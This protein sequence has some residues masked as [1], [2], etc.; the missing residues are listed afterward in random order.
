MADVTLRAEIVGG[1]KAFVDA[2]KQAQAAMGQ[3]ANE[4]DK[5]VASAKISLDGL[6]DMLGEVAKAF[7]VFGAAATGALAISATNAATF[8]NEMS[9]VLALLSSEDARSL[10]PQLAEGARQIRTE[11]GLAGQEVAEA[12][13]LAIGSGVPAAEAVDFLGKSA[14]AAVSGMVALKDVV[15]VTA[16][17]V[18]AM[19][20]EVSETQR[21]QDALAMA[22]NLGTVEWKDF[23]NGLGQVVPFAKQSGM[24]I[25]ELAGTV[26]TL[27]LKGFPADQAMTSLKAAFVGI[28]EPQT[29]AK[30]MFDQLGISLRD[31]EGKARP[32]LQILSEVRAK[33]AER[34]T[35]SLVDDQQ[36]ERD[37][38]KIADF[39]KRLD[40]LRKK[41]S[42]SS[43]NERLR[44]TQQ[45][46]D[47]EKKLKDAKAA[48]S[49][50]QNTIIQKLDKDGTVAALFGDVNAK[51]VGVALLSDNMA[52]LDTTL[53]RMNG[54]AGAVNQQFENFTLD[55]PLLKFRQLGQ[56][57]LILSERIGEL[58]LTTFAP[59]IAAITS[60]V[61]AT[62][63]W[64]R[65]NQELA[66]IVVVVGSVLGALALAVGALAGIVAAGLGTFAV[67]QTA[68]AGT[69]LAATFAS[70]GFMALAGSILLPIAPIL[71][72][73]AKIALIGVALYAAGKLIYENWSTIVEFFQWATGEI[74]GFVTDA[75]SGMTA[76]FSDWWNWV[77]DAFT[78]GWDSLA[79]GARSMAE[80]VMAYLRPV[81]D[82]LSGIW[83]SIRGAVSSAAS[84]VGMGGSTAQTAPRTGLT[85]PQSQLSRASAG[86][87][88]AA[89]ATAAS[90]NYGGVSITINQLPGESTEALA[91][92]VANHWRRRR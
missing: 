6:R 4:I 68:L 53:G 45:I 57:V 24:S 34:G 52:E 29:R 73:V 21:V 79:E 3:L 25:E 91:N 47:L 23:A 85:V 77:R 59:L 70:G 89:A 51:A 17:T 58:V 60:A 88:G 7:T 5:G 32:F 8:K 1:S 76:F 43:G 71:L 11:F 9:G 22:V 10:G 75:F 54:S 65:N 16:S 19:G 30:E 48:A 81:A 41:L 50:T 87:R 2:A 31:S 37:N 15:G 92:R 18:K 33:L 67:F 14:K 86:L 74:V 44:I 72:L 13:R 84:A 61:Q 49:E 78:D 90:T 20:Y 40:E 36:L 62:G 26:A 66:S 46:A 28:L 35:I 38:K 83:D 56:E 12:M 55:N 27:T 69:G 80:S 39:S 63:E 82:F 42:G 64:V